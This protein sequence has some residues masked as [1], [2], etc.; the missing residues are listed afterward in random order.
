MYHCPLSLLNWFHFLIC[1]TPSQ[2]MPC[3]QH[4]LI[5]EFSFL[6]LYIFILYIHVYYYIC[7]SSYIEI[8]TLFCTFKKKFLTMCAKNHLSKFI[9]TF[10]LHLNGCLILQCVP[11]SQFIQP[12]SWISGSNGQVLMQFQNFSLEG[13]YQIIF[14][15][16]M[17]ENAYLLTALQQ[18]MLSL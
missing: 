2:S 11:V 1:F 3:R 17:C 18:N 4:I 16:T 14:P 10:L 9:K 12:L 13:L 6:S 15:S 8:E 7:A 5:S